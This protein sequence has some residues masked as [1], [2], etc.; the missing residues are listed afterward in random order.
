MEIRGCSHQHGRRPQ[1][2]QP[3]TGAA[4]LSEAQMVMDIFA[5]VKVAVVDHFGL[6]DDDLLVRLMRFRNKQPL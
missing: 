1:V 6:K 5:G 4:M 2:P 3:C